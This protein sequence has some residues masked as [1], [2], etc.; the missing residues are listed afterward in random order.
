[1]WTVCLNLDIHFLM[2]KPS[3]EVKVLGMGGERQKPTVHKSE[4]TVPKYLECVECIHMKCKCVQNWR[5]SCAKCVQHAHCTITAMCASHHLWSNQ[6]QG[7]RSPGRCAT[8]S[9]SLVFSRRHGHARVQR[10]LGSI[11]QDYSLQCIGEC[12]FSMYPVSLFDEAFMPINI[13]FL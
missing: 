10:L 13:Y 5:K 8:Y 7:S 3:S 2:S 1:M 9:S 11:T 4:T 12:S 6:S